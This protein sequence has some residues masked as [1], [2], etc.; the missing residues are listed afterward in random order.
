MRRAE[1]WMADKEVEMDTSGPNGTEEGEGGTG[2]SKS[3]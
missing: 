1:G 3:A 2:D